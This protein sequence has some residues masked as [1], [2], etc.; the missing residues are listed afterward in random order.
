M[1]H[2]PAPTLPVEKVWETTS[3]ERRRMRKKKRKSEAR[4]KE[5]DLKADPFLRNHLCNKQ[6]V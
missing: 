5:T 1:Y 6:E 3:T 2:E 4:E